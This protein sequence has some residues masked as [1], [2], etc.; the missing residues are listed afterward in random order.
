MTL[1]LLVFTGMLLLVA[2]MAVGVLFGREPI[3]GTC[4]GLNRMFGEEGGSCEICGGDPARCD[5]D[6]ED[7]GTARGHAA[8]LAEDAMAP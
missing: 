8:A 4:G 7:A 6:E 3:S 1:F 2:A 5:G